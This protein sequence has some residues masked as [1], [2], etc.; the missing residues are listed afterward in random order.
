MLSARIESELRT[1]LR[2]VEAYTIRFSRE[3]Q[4]CLVQFVFLGLSSG[5]EGTSLTW[6]VAR[7]FTHLSGN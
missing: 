3:S 1:Q 5:S 6:R 4:Y 7:S 2:D